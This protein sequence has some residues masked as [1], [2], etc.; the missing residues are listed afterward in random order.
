VLE[1]ATTLCYAAPAWRRTPTRHFSRAAI[2]EMR[3][4]LTRKL[5]ERIN[6]VDLSGRVP[7]DILEL[8]DREALSLVTEGWAVLQELSPALDGAQPSEFA[9]VPDGAAPRA[10]NPRKRR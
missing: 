8:P 4:R 3:V 10:R 6:G 9:R 2:D 7:G 1:F 5:A